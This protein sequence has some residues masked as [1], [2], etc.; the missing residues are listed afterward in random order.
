MGVL[1]RHPLLTVVALVLL[2]LGLVVFATGVAVWR[3]AH[4]DDASR[5]ERADIIL[6]LGAAEY[7]GRPSPVF[8]GRLDHALLLY[9]QGRS[10]RVMVLG[11]KRP[12]DVT[13]EAEAG[14]EYL[15]A[16]GVPRAAAL[17]EPV[18]HTSL[19]SLRAA[20][21]YMREH[22]EDSAFLVSDPWHNLRLKRMASDLG[23]RGYVSATWT[24]A[25]RTE[26]TRLEGYL[27][28]TFAYLYYRTFGR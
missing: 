9:R 5:I 22:G 13:T 4:E 20:V 23:I 6:V 28:E 7:D 11:G 15:M 3:A 12:G 1:R 26:P 8:D 25:A 2:G 19:E 27:R 16:R 21:G 18:G 24:S 17:A 10:S 14:R